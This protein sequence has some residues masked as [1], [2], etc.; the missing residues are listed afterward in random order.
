VLRKSRV[1]A[2]NET[3]EERAVNIKSL[4]TSGDR[5]IRFGIAALAAVLTGGLL[6]SCGG[7]G[8]SQATDTRDAPLQLLPGTSTLFAT[9]PA[10]F[11]ASG[12]RPPYTLLTSNAAVLPVPSGTTGASIQLTPNVVSANTDV[13]ITLR[14]S[15]GATATA[16]ATVNPNFVNGD[17][18]VQGNSVESPNFTGCTA[19]GF[20]C[21]GQFGT[22]R[23]TLT[24]N[25]AP[26]R[27]RPV[28]FTAEQ[29][30]YQF[31]TNVVNNTLAPTIDA[32]TDET[33]TA[34]AILRANVNATLQVAQIRATDIQTGAFRLSTF[35]IRQT[36][37]SGQ[38]FTTVPNGWSVGGS[39]KNQCPG[40]VVDYIIFGGT[41]PYNIRTTISGVNVS[42]TITNTDNPNR[43]SATFFPQPCGDDG[44]A[45]VFT[46]TDATGRT[47]TAN[48]TVKPGTNDAPATT[49]L[50]LS[51][52]ALVL[53]C[54]QQ[55][56]VVA[57]ITVTGGGSQSTAPTLSTA[58]TTPVSPATALTVAAAA[59]GT[60]TVTRGNGTIS[61]GGT[62]RALANIVVG[63]GSAAPQTL[64]VDTPATCP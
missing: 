9:V 14:D 61:P 22:V 56:Q 31:V 7:G 52:A 30:G 2:E 53:A 13:T 44:Y 64:V 3:R 20:V 24:Q 32:I 17:L 10:N 36:T 26:V 21:A 18:T 54:G 60:I 49:T 37:L 25:G 43:F 16:T 46:I 34:T 39:L 57:A 51:P 11:T 62:G 59:N 19:V 27:S 38:D 29:G 4:L 33:G 8:A 50:A 35:V 45:P 5:L 41:P 42:P 23:V 58:V 48:L 63:A 6:T 1:T 40:G 55:A 47:I 12:G 28:R 15:A